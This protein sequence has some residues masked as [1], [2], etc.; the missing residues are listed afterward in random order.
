[1][2]SL[3]FDE[4][5]ARPV[6]C[7][8]N[9]MVVRVFIC[10]SE[11]MMRTGLKAALEDQPDSN[12]V[13]ECSTAREMLHKAHETK[14]NVTVIDSEVHDM[15][16]AEIIRRLR[17][18]SASG[19]NDIAHRV[20][21][22]PAPSQGS[23][24]LPPSVVVVI[25]AEGLML[26]GALAGASGILIRSSEPAAYVDAIKTVSYGH[27]FLSAGV[28]DY[29]INWLRA[30]Q[31]DMYAHI[32]VEGLTEREWEVLALVAKGLSN[33]EIA[34]ELFIVESTVKYHVSRMLRKLG[35]RDRVHAAIFGHSLGLY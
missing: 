27:A 6:C 12:V 1:M 23:G 13:G 19:R 16:V 8:V 4:D 17:K 24:S 15:D 2:R 32:D 20:A 30:Q 3:S 5:Y 33:S 29:L 10:M 14:P 18:D 21:Q 9:E 34:S 7:P 28:A 22:P 11:P 31:A 35:L 26:K 25:P